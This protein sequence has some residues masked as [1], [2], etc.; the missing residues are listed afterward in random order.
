M[1]VVVV[2]ACKQN[3]SESDL[4]GDVKNMTYEARDMVTV[5]RNFLKENTSIG[6]AQVFH[7]KGIAIDLSSKTFANNVHQAVARVTDIRLGNDRTKADTVFCLSSILVGSLG[8]SAV[9]MGQD[10]RYKYAPGDETKIY[11]NLLLSS[12]T[13]MR[14]VVDCSAI[15]LRNPKTVQALMTT[16][17][18][19]VVLNNLTQMTAVF[20]KHAIQQKIDLLSGVVNFSVAVQR[21]V[22]LF[23]EKDI[24]A[25][26]NK[27]N[28]VTISMGLAGSNICEVLQS[29]TV[30]KTCALTTAL[31]S[32]ADLVYRNNGFA[33]TKLASA[34]RKTLGESYWVEYQDYKG[35]K[36]L[37]TDKP[38]TYK[39]LA[40]QVLDNIFEGVKPNSV[41]FYFHVS[42]CYTKYIDDWR[43]SNLQPFGKMS[44]CEVNPNGG[45]KHPSDKAF[46]TRNCEELNRVSKHLK[47]LTGT[48]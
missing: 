28:G 35:C 9:M 25:A 30:I 6:L 41:V 26:V 36:V 42:D 5:F 24:A 18:G 47:A 19:R 4:E 17:A 12:G 33:D 45:A 16:S 14:G 43:K 46:N 38:T 39:S 31:F 13:L 27:L 40:I 44:R 8:L 11:A 32:V 23:A 37:L 2:A 15:L 10:G 48:K 29:R 34:I 1:L 20:Q 3:E 21:T 22:S 7:K